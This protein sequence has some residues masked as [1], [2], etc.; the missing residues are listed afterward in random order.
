MMEDSGFDSG[1]V[2]MPE[3]DEKTPINSTSMSAND[4]SECDANKTVIK[5][6][7]STA[8]LQKKIEKKIE[9]A[10]RSQSN[11]NGALDQQPRKSLIPINRLHVPNKMNVPL[12]DGAEQPLVMYQSDSSDDEYELNPSISHS[13]AR[14]ISKQLQKDGFSLDI[15][16]DDDDL[17]LIPPKSFNSQCACCHLSSTC[18][19]Q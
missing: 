18:V 9:Q 5:P 3:P 8:L 17:D 6:S 13:S 16:P 11:S 1:D 14:E 12:R 19:I 15:T 4:L 2:K 10:R 7:R